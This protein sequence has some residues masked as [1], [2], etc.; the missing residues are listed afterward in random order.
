MCPSLARSPCRPVRGQA[1]RVDDRWGDQAAIVQ[2]PKP[3]AMFRASAARVAEPEGERLL[4]PRE[5]R[6]PGQDTW[7][8]AWK[9]IAVNPILAGEVTVT[10]KAI[11]RIDGCGIASA[12]CPRVTSSASTA[13]RTASPPVRRDSRLS[14]PRT[15]SRR[16]RWTRQS[17]CADLGHELRRHPVMRRDPAGR[18]HASWQARRRSPDVP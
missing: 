2:S 6:G 14:Q 5:R 9:L 7:S 12:F 11:D 18:L 13:R 16:W 10:A 1:A 4:H 3:P 8:L 17:G 15:P